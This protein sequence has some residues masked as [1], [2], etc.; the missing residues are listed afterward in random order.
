MLKHMII[1]IA[2]L[3]DL[4]KLGHAPGRIEEELRKGGYD[5]PIIHYAFHHT[6]NDKERLSHL[7]WS[8]MPGKV[9]YSGIY[10]PD[11]EPL[12]ERLTQTPEGHADALA[13]VFFAL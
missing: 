9:W 12:E 5:S 7:R 1:K 4:A 10:L 3:N 11:G 8:G 6:T 2:S 13:A